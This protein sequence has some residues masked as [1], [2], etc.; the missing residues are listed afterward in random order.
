MHTAAFAE[1]CESFC[2]KVA[3]IY[4]LLGD[5]SRV[6]LFPPWFVEVWKC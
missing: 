5:Y 3:I 4:F 6:L 2:G 1:L